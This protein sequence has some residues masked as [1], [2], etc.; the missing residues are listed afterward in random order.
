MGRRENTPFTNERR[1]NRRRIIFLITEDRYFWLHH[2]PLA[3][4]ARDAG[5]EVCVATPPG[6][7]RVRIEGEGFLYH[8]LRLQRGSRNPLREARAL[9]DILLLY[10]RYAPDIVHQVSIKPVLYGSVAARLTGVPAVVNA[11]TGLGYVFVPRGGLSALLR[12]IVERAYAL[13]L[14]GKSARVLFENPDDLTLFVDRRIVPPDRAVLI[15]GCGVDTEEFRPSPHPRGDRAGATILFVSRMLW[16]KGAGDL[17]RAWRIL[18]ERKVPGRLLLV[19][20]PDPASPASIPRQRLVEWGN[21]EEVEWLGYRDDLP[22]IIAEADIVC[23]PS[24]YRE[25]IPM[26]LL[27]GASAGK[28]LVTT[29]TPGCREIVRDGLNGL[30]VPPQDA[31][32]LADA[33]ERLLRDAPLR[34]ALGRE[35]RKMAVERFSTERVIEKTF[36]VYEEMGAFSPRDRRETRG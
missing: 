15:L 3:R 20:D 13:C 28:P 31:V 14:A 23:L 21:E 17:M 26:I 24:Y 2:L 18:R 34:E 35:G 22:R 7:F 6:D 33:L 4:V 10:R 8:P 36:S 30:L 9:I 16:H 25:G 29:D 5:L 32:A 19:G 1:G 12:A 27:K 11:V